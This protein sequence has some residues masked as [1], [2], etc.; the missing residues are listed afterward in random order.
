MRRSRVVS[1]VLLLL[2]GAG[3]LVTAFVSDALGEAPTTGEYSLVLLVTWGGLFVWWGLFFLLSRRRGDIAS[4]VRAL[5]PVVGK[6]EVLIRESL[7]PPQL[8]KDRGPAGLHL[9]W[10]EPGYTITLAFRDGV[11]QG[12][13]H[14]GPH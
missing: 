12:V 14:E 5:Q 11:C 1:G 13:V 2:M 4:A 3:C 9:T 6:S 8:S 10:R 7:G